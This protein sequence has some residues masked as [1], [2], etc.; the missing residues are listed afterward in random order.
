[1]P[2]YRRNRVPGGTCFFTVNLLDRRSE[3][4]V[5][6][7]DA[8]RDAVRVRPTFPDVCPLALAHGAALMR[9]TSLLSAH[10]KMQYQ[11]CGQE[12]DGKQNDRRHDN[13]SRRDACYGQ[14]RFFDH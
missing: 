9:P 12:N 11:H 14:N 10:V 6:H 2:D 4:L 3:L 7:I 13:D 8:L 5:T 1:M